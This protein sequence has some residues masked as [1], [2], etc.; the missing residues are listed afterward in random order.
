MLFRSSWEVKGVRNDARMKQFPFVAEQ[1]KSSTQKGKYWD[2]ASYNKPQSVSI[3][4]DG[5]IESSLTQSTQKQPA[6]KVED[7]T[8]SVIYVAPAKVIAK[9]IDPSVKSSTDQ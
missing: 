9:P 7:K 2:A 8:G 3:G 4:Y 6:T 1:E 5:A